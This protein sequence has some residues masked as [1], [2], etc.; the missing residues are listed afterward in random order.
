MINKHG[1]LQS[2]YILLKKQRHKCNIQQS[3]IL[4]YEENFNSRASLHLEAKIKRLVLPR[5]CTF[6]Q[7]REKNSDK[8]WD[9]SL[10]DGCSEV[11]IIRA[12][13]LWQ[14]QRGLTCC[15][16][17]IKHWCR[18]NT[19]TWH[20]TYEE[21]K[22]IDTRVDLSE[23]STSW[24]QWCVFSLSPFFFIFWT[25]PQQIMTENSRHHTN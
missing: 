6:N 20:V 19:S 5:R 13:G 12:P 2:L 22:R 17:A 3:E 9:R 8:K 23:I 11:M 7:T 1:N 18:Y 10:W 4:T 15:R 25:F 14:V 16:A 21:H 24:G